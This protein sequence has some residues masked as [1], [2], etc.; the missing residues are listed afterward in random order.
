[1]TYELEGRQ[2]LLIPVQHALY[3]FWLPEKTA[4]R[5]TS[6]ANYCG[7]VVEIL[8]RSLLIASG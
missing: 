8:Q 4:S 6:N 1:M 2:Y 3:A 5:A 7:K